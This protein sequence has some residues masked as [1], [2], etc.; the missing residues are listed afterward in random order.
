MRRGVSQT[1]SERER[2]AVSESVN[3]EYCLVGIA[4]AKK[5][6]SPEKHKS[7][8]SSRETTEPTSTRSQD[9]LTVMNEGPRPRRG[10]DAQK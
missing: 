2:A 7:R 10:P 3:A 9:P 1:A 8:T 4:P 5:H 6:S